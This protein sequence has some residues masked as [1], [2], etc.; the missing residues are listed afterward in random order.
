M[1]GRYVSRATSGKGAG[2]VVDVPSFRVGFAKAMN[3]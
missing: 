2:L 1:P 3:G